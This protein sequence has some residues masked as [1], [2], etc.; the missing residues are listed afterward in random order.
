MGSTDEK[1]SQN[2]MNIVELKGQ[3]D[4][5]HST[6]DGVKETVNELKKDIDKQSE[7]SKELA[8]RIAEIG[9]AANILAQEV[10]DII[11]TRNQINSN[12]WK[13]IITVIISV[14]IYTGKTVVDKI[15]DNRIK[16]DS[17]IENVQPSLPKVISPPNVK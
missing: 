13:I 14:I 6:I 10:K 5:L 2:S 12:L 11:I 1:I 8:E 17:K 16:N 9:A 7:D 15:H 3:I 4:T